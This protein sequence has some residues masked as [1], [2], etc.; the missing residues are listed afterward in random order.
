MKNVLITGGAGFIGANFIHLLLKMEGDI[1]IF[2]YDALT[3]SGSLE[4]LRDIEKDS[5]YHFIKGDI[6]DTAKVYLTIKEN[7][8]DTIVHF[9]AETHVDRSISDPGQFVKT[10]IVG[11][12]NLLEAAR[13]YW[14]NSKT[15]LTE[16]T[17][18]HHISTDEVFGTLKANEPAWS[19]GIA[20]APSSPYS[21]SKASS[22]HL[23][24]S[25]GHT[26][27]LPIT[28][29][30]SSNN[31]GNYQFPEKLVPLIILN[32]VEGKHLPIYGK[33]D[34]I[35]DWL[36]VKDHC[37]AILTVLKFG[38]LGESY[39]IGGGNQITNL[40]IVNLICD[41]L[42]EINPTKSPRRKLVQFV[43]DRPGHDRRYAMDCRKI[44]NG[45]G[46]KPHYT[47]E[48][49]LRETVEWYLCHME[50][51][52]TIRKQLEYLSWIEKNYN[53]RQ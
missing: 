51:V 52:S 53:N 45:L 31:Y 16:A 10:N 50:W 13:K 9:A 23:V 4:N 17:R 2:N 42:D 35:R 25:Y 32:A 36:H 15:L 37:E 5:R 3:Y 29:T 44:M 38:N 46:W 48:N 6:C 39:N 12:Y 40:S 30:N 18:F 11:T 49:G 28:I 43:K 33:G 8:I 41:L 22:D 47:L 24:R 19:E 1:Q 7:R 27:G 20:Y 26:Y 21:A 34:Q 14:L